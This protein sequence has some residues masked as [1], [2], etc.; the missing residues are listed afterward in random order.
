MS[1]SASPEGNWNIEF[2]FK[3]DGTGRILEWNNNGDTQNYMSI[4]S[5]TIRLYYDY[6]SGDNVFNTSL[7]S[8]YTF[9]DEAWHHVSYSYDGSKLSCFI[10]G[11][12]QNSINR[13]LSSTGFEGNLYI[14]GL[15]NLTTP[16]GFVGALDELTFYDRDLS[17]QEIIEIFRAGHCGKSLP[18]GNAAPAVDAGRDQSVR[19]INSQVGLQGYAVDDVAI[20]D[21]TWSKKS[22]PGSLTFSNNKTLALSLIHI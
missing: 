21:V 19:A 5:T 15:P 18:N 7:A 10:D 1:N 20:T 9:S 4:T 16:N 2:W 3:Y 11:A 12:F 14:G 22:G 17:D 6:F 13:T 8:S